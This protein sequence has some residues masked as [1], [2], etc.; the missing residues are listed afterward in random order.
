MLLMQHL[1][2]LRTVRAMLH[3]CFMR[4]ARTN[5]RITELGMAVHALHLH[6]Q[7]SNHVKLLTTTY[8]P[9]EHVC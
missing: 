3:T 4:Y 7:L 1:A 5:H 2:S 8:K 9:S 6:A